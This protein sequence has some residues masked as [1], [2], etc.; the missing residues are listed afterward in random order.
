MIIRARAPLRIGLAGGGTDVAPYCDLYGGAVVNVTIGRYA[1]ATLELLSEDK[2]LLEATDRGEVKEYPLMSQIPLDGYLDLHKGVYNRIIRDYRKGEALGIR[3]STTSDAAAGSGL[4][5][6]STVIV[7]MIQ[8]FAELLSLPLGEY[9]IA[10]LAYEIERI[11][12]KLNGG[13]QD[14]YAATF[15]GFNFM[16]F[17]AGDRVIV[18]PLPIKERV[19]CELE[20]SLILY[21]TGVSRLSATIIDEQS[22]NVRKGQQ[23]AID[24]MHA[25]KRESI[26]MKEHILSGDICALGKTLQAGWEAK[27]RMAG[28]ITNEHIE[29]IDKTARNAGAIAGK[30]SGAGGGGFMF[31]I[32]PPEARQRVIKALEP[33]GGSATGCHFTMRGATAW[34]LS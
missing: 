3:I 16:E 1:Y 26:A 21:F 19:V 15:G 12:L 4:G 32:T 33:L 31:F 8:A 14:Q 29:H 11:D 10:H 24:A 2:I 9:E 34:S 18:N 6:S 5:S 22:S 23:I 30:I 7:S 17:M 27:K 13:K 28:S 25:L 20:A